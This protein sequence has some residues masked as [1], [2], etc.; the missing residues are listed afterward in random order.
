MKKNLL[1]LV[2]SA[3]LITSVLGGCGNEET[4]PSET[5]SDK[6]APTESTSTTETP[7]TEPNK[8]S[9]VD[10]CAK[11]FEGD[12]DAI[13]MRIPGA[14]IGIGADLTDDQADEL[15]EINEALVEASKLAPDALAGKIDRLNEPFQTF[16]D[17]VAAGG[18]SLNMDTS[19][20]TEDIADVMTSCTEAGFSLAS[21]TEAIEEEPEP[22][23]TVGQQN[24][25]D[26]AESYLEYSAFS[27]SGLIDQLEYEGFTKK[28]AKFAVDYIDVNWKQQAVDKAESYLDSSSFSRSGLIDQL[29]YEGF[30]KKQATFGVEHIDVNWKKQAAKKAESYLESSS[31]SRSG[32]IDQLEY[33]GF[34]RAQAEYGVKAVGY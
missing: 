32:L 30:T 3:A 15:T 13:F 14:L 19:H 8:G 16:A 27:R 24:A 18:G 12:D 6:A 10:A 21:D 28:Q 7:A 9:A 26:K 17:V 31:F 22:E 20:V 33:E 25:V 4:T 1:T 2:A 34:T 29:E 23:L 11:I 5:S